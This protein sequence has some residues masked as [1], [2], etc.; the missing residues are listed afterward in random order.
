MLAR[1]TPQPVRFTVQMHLRP[2]A[3]GIWE[4][5]IYEC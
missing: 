2:S 3:A 1:L 4:K 5:A